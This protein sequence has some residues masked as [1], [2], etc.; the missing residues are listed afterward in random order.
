VCKY[1]SFCA[2]L[3]FGAGRLLVED[4][5]WLELG[6]MF[7]LLFIVGFLSGWGRMLAFAKK[8]EQGWVM[9]VANGV[10]AMPERRQDYLYYIPAQQ[11]TL[12]STDERLSVSSKFNHSETCGAFLS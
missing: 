8:S 9:K 5:G 6:P 1:R 11:K 3:F 7:V 10:L 2:V 4:V 12:T